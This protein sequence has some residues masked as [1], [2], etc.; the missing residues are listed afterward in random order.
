M[1]G[2]IK[3]YV[4]GGQL[5]DAVKADYKKIFDDKDFWFLCFVSLYVGVVLGSRINDF[6]EVNPSA[7][8]IACGAAV[9]ATLSF[10]AIESNREIKEKEIERNDLERY[11]DYCFEFTNSTSS[12]KTIGA[13]LLKLLDKY[14][15][16]ESNLS[17]IRKQHGEVLREISEI[18]GYKM[19]KSSVKE[20]RELRLEDIKSR[21]RKFVDALQE[22]QEAIDELLDE[23]SDKCNIV[24]TC[25]NKALLCY[26]K[27][28]SNHQLDG[29][30]IDNLSD[31][32]SKHMDDFVESK[33]KLFHGTAARLDER[34]YGKE[35]KEKYSGTSIGSYKFPDIIEICEHIEEVFRS[36]GLHV[37]RKS[38]RYRLVE[39]RCISLA[40]VF[41]IIA[42][43]NG[44]SLK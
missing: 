43:I 33:N 28:K 31:I 5:L 3:S 21:G 14:E 12:A 37:E 15:D 25:N 44:F 8:F 7:I 1:W 32:A 35:E 10:L 9:A 30:E 17:S 36:P 18:N 20:N 42:I 24:A 27:V 16:I 11:G 23:F 4:K 38:L 22:V 6:Y 26:Y 34:M 40:L 39:N 19:K 41:I 13:R 29:I 2:K